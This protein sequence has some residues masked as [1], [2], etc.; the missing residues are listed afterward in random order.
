MIDLHSHILPGIDDGAKDLA[1]ALAMARMAVADNT[2]HIACTPHFMPGVYDNNVSEVTQIMSELATAFVENGIDLKLVR[3]GDI[4]IAPD[5]SAK[6]AVGTLPVLGT[7]N[8][9]LF[10]PPHHVLPPGI[11][12]L[13][14]NTMEAGYIPVLTHPERLTWIEK[15]Y[16]TMCKLDEMGL[17]IQLTAGSITGTFGKRAQYWSERML[18]EGRVD[19][20]ASDAHNTQ[21]RPPGLSRA[22][23]AIAARLDDQA[24]LR[25]VQENP[26]RILD[27]MPVL[28]KSRQVTANTAPKKRGFLARIGLE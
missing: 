9:F 20:I 4:H 24:A 19:I 3:G 17:V 18:D 5:I 16:E 7:S 11:L 12:N 8:Y 27:N 14:K 2:T 15:N 10:E 1:M 6:L 21:S 23:D 13:C 28:L 25:M 22:R 26:R